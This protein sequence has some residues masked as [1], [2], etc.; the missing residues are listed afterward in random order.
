[1]EMARA[2]VDHPRVLLLD[3]PTS[4][5]GTDEVDLLA[6]TIMRAHR[7][8]G[9]AVVLV[10][11]DVPF[12]MKVCGRIIVLHLGQTLIDDDPET[13]RNDPRVREAYLGSRV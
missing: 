7:E 11:H 4:G 10:E 13:V 2:I 5:L 9:C 3:E 8:E 1:M 6:E 12:V